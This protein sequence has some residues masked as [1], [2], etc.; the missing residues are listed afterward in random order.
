M[1]VIVRIRN[2][3][4][5]DEYGAGGASEGDIRG[6]S[7]DFIKNSYG[8]VNLEE[9]LLV[10]EADSPSMN[11]VIDGGVGYIPNDSYDELDSDSIKFWEA[12]VS[13]DTLSRT[14]SIDSNP[15][16]Q[17]RIDLICLKIDPGKTPDLNASNIAELVA[18]KGTAGSG[19]PET[20][21]FH[22]P[23]ASVTVVN[24]ATE[25]E[26]EDI[27]DEREQIK[28]KEAVIPDV[29]SSQIIT[30]STAPTP[31]GDKRRNDLYITA[32]S[33]AMTLQAP[34]GVPQNG[35]T[36]IVRIKDNGT[37]RAISYNSIYRG[38]GFALPT[39]TVANKTI[40]LGAIYN[41]SAEKWDVIAVPQEI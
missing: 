25:I 30:T 11:V 35:N 21:P 4:E 7:A 34:S 3:M 29:V 38:I 27:T 20:P 23:L 17:T 13:G 40:Y 12:V 18:V 1:S 39:S 6:N 9:H 5:T 15:S 37:A 14:V 36:L 41:S 33:S 32:L 28:F 10:H 22:L 16:G 24:G 2:G 31:T 19:R 26:N 8:V